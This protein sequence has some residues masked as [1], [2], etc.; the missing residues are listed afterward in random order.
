M[1][2]LTPR[3]ISESRANPSDRELLRGSFSGAES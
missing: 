3:R 2:T 1:S